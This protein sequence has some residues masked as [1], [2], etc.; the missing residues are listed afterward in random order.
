MARPRI[1]EAGRS[2]GAKPC[3]AKYASL[4]L[5]AHLLA[6]SVQQ[7]A[8]LFYLPCERRSSKHQGF[9]AP[10]KKAPMRKH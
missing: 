9:Q 2:C 1:Q 6:H 3:F 8:A 10:N 4:T 7:Q 5:L